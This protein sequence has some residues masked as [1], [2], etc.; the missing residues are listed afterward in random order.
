MGPRPWPGGL[1]QF[2]RARSGYD[3]A[4]QDGATAASICSRG[5]GPLPPPLSMAFS[6]NISLALSGRAKRARFYGGADVFARMK[7]IVEGGAVQTHRPA[8]AQ[9]DGGTTG[10]DSARGVIVEGR[11]AKV[12]IGRRSDRPS[13]TRTESARHGMRFSLR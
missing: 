7:P 2:D 10:T 4:G 11:R 9:A 5:A 1:W 6:A 13:M 8:G 12:H 3:V